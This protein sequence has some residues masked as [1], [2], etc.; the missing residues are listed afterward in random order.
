MITIAV[1]VA[2]ITG[3]ALNNFTVV[4]YYRP[5]IAIGLL[6][7]AAYKPHFRFCL[8]ILLQVVLF[9][10]SFLIL[11]YL[12]ARHPTPLIDPWL[13]ACDR[14]LGFRPLIQFHNL[15]LQLAYNS[16]LLQTAATI[17]YFG[18]TNQK[19]ALT[20][21]V[22]R[23]M[24]AA[25]FVLGC[26]L[27]L[28]AIGPY[29]GPQQQNYFQQFAALRSG[30]GFLDFNDAEGLICFPSFHIIWCLLLV[31][32]WRRWWSILLNAA[33]IVSTLTSGWHYGSDVVGGI[34][35]YY[36]VCWLIVPSEEKQRSRL[37]FS[38]KNA[39]KVRVDDKIDKNDRSEANL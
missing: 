24:V 16:L 22:A 19:H 4:G 17:I 31:S 1:F 12:A 10:S 32:T 3:I 33:V 15:P 27:L 2:A 28:P 13:A 6:A 38:P 35:V 25:M 8:L 5:A 20:C 18:F 11:S 23:F 21:F 36:V 37:Y 7:I 29:V 26:F 39:N 30:N 9:S 14:A 34:V